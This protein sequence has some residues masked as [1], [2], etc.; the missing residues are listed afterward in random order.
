VKTIDRIVAVDPGLASGLAYFSFEDGDLQLLHSAELN[1]HELGDWC[2]SHFPQLGSRLAVV[3]ER[4]VIGKKTTTNTQ[5]PWSL[6]CNG[7]MQWLAYKHGAGDFV[8]Q[9]VSEAKLTFSNERLHHLGYWHRGGDGH[10][11]DAIR[12]GLLWALNHRWRDEKLLT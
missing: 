12:H 8:L 5:A 11:R 3:C 7:M 2:E 10:A 1:W 9:K 6:E 4:F